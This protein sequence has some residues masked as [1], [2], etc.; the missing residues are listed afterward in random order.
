M[1]NCW[2]MLFSMACGLTVGTNIYCN[3]LDC[4]TSD[5]ADSPIVNMERF[6]R[7]RLGINTLPL[8]KYTLARIVE[9]NAPMADVW[10][11]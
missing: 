4:G 1:S 11:I 2:A 9:I 5:M 8:L 10:C 3:R 6:Y 7:C